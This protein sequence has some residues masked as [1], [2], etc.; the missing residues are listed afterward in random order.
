VFKHHAIKK[1]GA[2]VLKKKV[3]LGSYT[4]NRRESLG[5]I[6]LKYNP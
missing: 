6:H 1:Y 5:F 4:E 2:M 3:L